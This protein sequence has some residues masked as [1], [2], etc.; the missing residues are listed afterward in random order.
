M[1]SVCETLLEIVKKVP[2]WPLWTGLILIWLWTG[3]TLLKSYKGTGR[4]R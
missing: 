3:W 1:T 4:P 2:A